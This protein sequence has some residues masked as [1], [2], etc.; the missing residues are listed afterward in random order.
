MDIESLVAELRKPETLEILGQTLQPHLREGGRTLVY[1][2]PYADAIGHLAPEPHYLASLY[3]DEYDRIVLLTPPR[4]VPKMKRPLYD[5]LARD[6]GMAETQHA[7]LLLLRDLDRGI[8]RM[9]PFELFLVHTHKFYRAYTL[10]RAARKPMRFL[11]LSEEMRSAG[12]RWLRDVDIEPGTPFVTLHM[13][14]EGYSHDSSSAP[15]GK[16]RAVDPA[17]FRPAVDWLLEAGYAVIRLGAAGAPPFDHPSPRMIDLAH[18]PRAEDFLDIYLMATC[19]FSLNCQSGPEALARAFGRPSVNS[20]LLPTVMSHHLDSDIFLFKRLYRGDSTEPLSYAE[21][22]EFMLPNRLI[23]GP[24]PDI[25]WY[26][27]HQLRAKDC[28]SEDLLAAVQEMHARVAEGASE[29]SAANDRFVEMSR[30]YQERI[31]DN[32]IARFQGNDVYAYAHRMGTLSA[33]W[34]GNNPWFLG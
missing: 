28:S 33:A 3:G 13:R 30:T 11:E 16:L 23:S 2:M 22:L 9:G 21:Q 4:A 5:L 7:P 32:E 34:A 24:L 8:V 15:Y 1:S 10:H 26:Q 31:A 12:D 18:D 25:D 17:G 14:D 29:E 20:N 27:A 6:F 19:S